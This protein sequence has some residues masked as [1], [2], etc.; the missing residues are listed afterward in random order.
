MKVLKK[1]KDGGVE[2]TVYAYWLIE[3]KSVFSIAILKFVGASRECYHTHAFNSIS[4]LLKGR[5]RESFLDFNL[6][7]KERPDK[8]Y[9]PSIKPIITTRSNFHKVNSTGTSW[10]LTFRGPWDKKWKEST[11]KEGIYTLTTGRIRLNENQSR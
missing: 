5:L 10:V 2:S 7:R 8:V 6:I 4:W 3:W 9:L 1:D 11:E